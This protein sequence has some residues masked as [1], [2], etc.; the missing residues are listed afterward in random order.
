M[1][2][3]VIIIAGFAGIG[4]TTINDKYSNVIDLDATPYVYDDSNLMHLT[5]EERKGRDDRLPNPAW[6][7]NYIEAIK[8]AKEKYNIILVWERPDIVN[9]YIKAGIDFY[10]CY[11]PSEHLDLYKKRYSDRGNPKKYETKKMKEYWERLEFYE[12]IKDLKRI[13]L[14]E[15]YLEDYLINQGY[16]LIPNVI[17]KN[18]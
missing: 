12:T 3:E 2:R 16:N 1:E 6:P 13:I 11:P 15:Q 14:N 8:K 5:V 4:K 7:E 10:V 9:E 17:Q 18:H